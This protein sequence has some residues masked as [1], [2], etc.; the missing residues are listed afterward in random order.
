MKA[1][2]I[3]IIFNINYKVNICESNMIGILMYLWLTIEWS[4]TI[5]LYIIYELNIRPGLAVA[6]P[7]LREFRDTVFNYTQEF[8][9][10]LLSLKIVFSI[11]VALNIICK[12]FKKSKN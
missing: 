9:K 6:L 7:W 10:E 4:S 3:N 12:V 2:H 1:S 11:V 8:Y 5:I